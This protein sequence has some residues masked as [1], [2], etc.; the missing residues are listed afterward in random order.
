MNAHNTDNSSAMSLRIKK[1]AIGLIQK[2][3]NKSTPA[4]RS[5]FKD[6]G[7]SNILLTS[8]TEE[9]PYAT[10]GDSHVTFCEK[11][12]EN[13]T[14]SESSSTFLRALENEKKR[15]KKQKTGGAN[16]KKKF[17]SQNG[18]ANVKTLLSGVSRQIDGL[19]TSTA[20]LEQ[21][22]HTYR[23]LPYMSTRTVYT[24]SSPPTNHI[25]SSK[26]FI[27]SQQSVAVPT[28]SIDDVAIL[29]EILNEETTF[30]EI[31]NYLSVIYGTKKR[32][33]TW[34]MTKKVL[35]ALISDKCLANFTWTGKSATKDIKKMPFKKMNSI[36]RV[37]V[38][39]LKK[40]DSSYDN[41]I[42]HDDVVKHILKYA[43]L[44]KNETE[45]VNENENQNKES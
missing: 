33:V 34:G 5:E 4:H 43:Y 19:S 8:S 29:N 10:D 39:A 24:N 44:K 25:G 35:L 23:N 13:S 26:V 22:I 20:K 36:H 15:R 18:F 1:E 6:G 28:Q 30:D 14:D 9:D 40:I 31:L 42:F 3:K 12:A 37:V 32:R 11:Q 7:S 21:E 45:N 27:A 17:K 2:Y 16:P 41:N 38:M